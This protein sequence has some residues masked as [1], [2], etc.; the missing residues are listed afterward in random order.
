MSNQP[1]AAQKMIG[2]FAPKLVELTA[3]VLFGDVWQRGSSRS[4]IA[5]WC[6]SARGVRKRFA[7]Q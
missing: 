5:V 3:R 4:A 1:S 2:K 7:V 6:N